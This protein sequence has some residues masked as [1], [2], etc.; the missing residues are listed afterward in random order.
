MSK[1]LESTF[2]G[3]VFWLAGP[4]ELKPYKPVRLTVETVEDSAAPPVSFL[5]V[6]RSLK[7]EGPADWSSRLDDYLYGH[8]SDADE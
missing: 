3:A 4:I 8:Q 7:L 5:E 6:A 1:V 2:D